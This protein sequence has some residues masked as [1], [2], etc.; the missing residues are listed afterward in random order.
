MTT[1]STT[2]ALHECRSLSHWTSQLGGVEA[3]LGSGTWTVHAS[4]GPEL[5]EWLHWNN[6]QVHCRQVHLLLSLEN[7]QG[8][9]IIEEEGEEEGMWNSLWLCASDSE[10]K[11][12]PMWNSITGLG[13]WFMLSVMFSFSPFN[14]EDVLLTYPLFRDILGTHWLHQ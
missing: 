12:K 1:Q 6:Q 11:T 4:T 5:T 9:E 8:P 10:N 3:D 2:L 14:I 13:D 7:T